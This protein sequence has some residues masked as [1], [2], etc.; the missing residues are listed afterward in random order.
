M[1]APHALRKQIRALCVCMDD[2]IAA[3]TSLTAPGRR[4]MCLDEAD[5]MVDMGFEEEI[6]EVMSFFKGQRQTLMFSATMP[7]KILKFAESA[8]VDPVTVNVGRAGATNKDIVQHVEFVKEEDRMR[9]L[10]DALQKTPPPVLIFSEVRALRHNGRRR[11][12]IPFLT[13]TESTPSTCPEGHLVAV[14]AEQERRRRHP[15]VPADPGRG[16][17]GHP[18]L[19]RPG[20]AQLGNGRVQGGEEGR[21]HRHRRRLQRARFPAHRARHQLRHA[22]GER[23]HFADSRPRRQ[24]RPGD[25]STAGAVVGPAASRQRFR[26]GDLPDAAQEI[27]NYVHRIGRTGRAGKKGAATTFVTSRVGSSILLDLKHILR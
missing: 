2:S 4:F 16:G 8:L 7:Q 18:R 5:R 9:H 19:E 11:T 3:T 13:F 20:G 27:E 15:R 14:S 10:C 1:P 25:L 17:R 21:P 12:R 22:S 26:C 24:H 23:Q 6:R